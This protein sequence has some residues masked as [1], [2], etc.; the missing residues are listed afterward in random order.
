MKVS[1]MMAYVAVRVTMAH[2]SPRP[3]EMSWNMRRVT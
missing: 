1:R 2:R 3:S